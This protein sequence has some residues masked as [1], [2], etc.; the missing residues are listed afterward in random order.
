M[1]SDA[2]HIATELA[3]VAARL[4]VDEGQEYATAKRQAVKLLGLTGSRVPLPD[5]ASMDAA[6]REHI[7]IFCA[8]TQPVELRALREIALI[9]LDRLV[10]F[11]P[12]L[13]G[14][15]W[16]GTA[17]RHSDVYIQLFCDDPKA[18]EWRL[19]DKGLDYQVGSVMGWKGE[20]VEALSLRVRCDALA[21]WVLVHLM[22]YDRDDVRGALKPDAQGRKP[23]GD[24]EAVR[25]LLSQA[26]GGARI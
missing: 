19:L 1:Y 21:Q 3:A 9:W 12:Y 17:T 7:A 14:A 5:A 23:R 2:T 16:H 11:S 24:A 4:V 6:V 22:V 25:A 8:D 26:E 20:P 18:A 10:E 13:S 15:V